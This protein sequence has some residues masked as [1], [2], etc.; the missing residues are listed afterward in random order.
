MNNSEQLAM[1]MLKLENLE[2]RNQGFQAEIKAI[3]QQIANMQSPGAILTPPPVVKFTPPVLNMVDVPAVSQA[4]SFENP[5]PVQFSQ[6]SFSSQFS[7]ENMAK[8]DF[9]K[10]VGEN[11]ISK[12]G[13]LILILGV[14]IGA[15]YAIEH[16]MI[17]PLTRVILGYCVGSILLFLSLKLKEKYENFS[18]VLI[19][20][21]IAIMYFITY[22][23]HD[24][25]GIIPQAIAFIMMVVFTCFGVYTA[26]K[27][28]KQVIAHIGLV[29]A[30]AVPFLLSDGSGKV[31]VLFTYMAI[32]NC[33]ILIISF[34]RY[35][36]PLLYVAFFFT[37]VIF[38]A[39]A[40][41]NPNAPNHDSITLSFSLIFF[42][43]FYSCA[44]FYKVKKGEIS[45]FL[46][47]IIILA[48][49]IAYYGI[50][51][52]AL[53]NSEAGTQFLGLFTVAN[54]AFHFAVSR[55]IVSKKI[56]DQ[57]L[58]FLLVSLAITFITV[59]APV[60]LDGGYIT[61]FWAV[62]AA[63]LFYF[64]RIRKIIVYEKLSLALIVLAFLSLIIIWLTY[65]DNLRNAEKISTWF[66]NVDFLTAVIFIVAFGWM[67]Y[68]SKKPNEN[69]HSTAM[70]N[71]TLTY[72][73]PGILL[74]TLYMT[75]RMEVSKYFDSQLIITKVTVKAQRAIDEPMIYSNTNLNLLKISWIY[76]YSLLFAVALTFAN[77]KKIKV[78]NLATVNVFFNL[79]LMIAFLIQGLYNLSLLRDNYILQTHQYFT[80]G[81]ENILVR[82]IS[83]LCVALLLI[84]SYR[85]SKSAIVKWK[86]RIEFDYFLYVSMLW[87]LS[88]EL[89]HIIAMQR[90]VSNYKLGLSILWGAYALFLIAIGL[91]KNKKHLRIGAIVLFG[92]TL[93]KLFLY[94]I[95][96]LDTIDK[97]IVFVS[98]GGLL[99][100]ISFLYNKYKHL[101]IDESEEVEQV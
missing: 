14:G 76:I 72:L 7:R 32:I 50:S 34:R 11:L 41:D 44:L 95:D 9:E 31:L 82:Y 85:L 94:D 60:Q 20:G 57:K 65:Y 84:A 55:L 33:G 23:A 49:A 19:S 70:L 13:I 78:V 69:P 61:I 59:A 89:V 98:L 45:T 52:C 101:I 46:D 38:L 56:E 54:S 83:F 62:E 91:A 90:Y 22:A 68:I 63:A 2:V 4:S 3:K 18:A 43:I 75:F 16:E 28:N 79:A 29:G 97:T 48:N 37:W 99:L 53:E 71:N 6:P 30:Y 35:W 12:I 1:L 58:I 74:V 10:F 15:R 17:S 47:V 86:I 80:N 24:F 100:I 26:L 87:V 67:Y 36:K 81:P 96:H 8:S 27:Y 42:L 21:A 66:L 88:S 73:I 93:I 92:V 5:N 39:W 40:L 25:Y 77:L 51:Y 64:S